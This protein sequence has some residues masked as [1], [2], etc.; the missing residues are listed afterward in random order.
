ML[1]TNNGQLYSH[2]LMRSNVLNFAPNLQTFDFYQ[3]EFIHDQNVAENL[4]MAI[5][6]GN[7]GQQESLSFVSV[8]HKV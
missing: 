3:H 1:V 4:R 6:D 2:P 5:L 8:E 7:T